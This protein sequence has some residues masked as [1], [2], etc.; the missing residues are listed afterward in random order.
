MKTS[1]KVISKIN[2]QLHTKA[3]S[4]L[5]SKIKNTKIRFNKEL[6]DTNK[7]TKAK[8]IEGK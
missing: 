1:I 5:F 6:F 7:V 8:V 3:P 2:S 4:V